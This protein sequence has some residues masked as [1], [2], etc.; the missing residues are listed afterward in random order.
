[1]AVHSHGA[2]MSSSLHRKI[3]HV[4]IGLV[5]KWQLIWSLKAKEECSLI[6][7]R[8]SIPSVYS[9]QLDARRRDEKSS[10]LPCMDILSFL[11]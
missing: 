9:Q 1:M 7:S 6:K 11:N 5:R 3:V 2:N 8:D 10:A 4:V